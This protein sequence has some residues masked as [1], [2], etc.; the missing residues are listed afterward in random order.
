MTTSYSYSGFLYTLHA[1]A[2]LKFLK[3][4]NNLQTSKN[5]DSLLK[6]Q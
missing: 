3:T 1:N 5:Q 6:L 2:L 4:S